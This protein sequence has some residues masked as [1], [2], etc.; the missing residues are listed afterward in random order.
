MGI[1]DKLKRGKKPEAPQAEKKSVVSPVVA[2]EKKTPSTPHKTVS[3]HAYRILLKPLVSEKAALRETAGEYTFVVAQTATK[4]DIKQAVAAVYGVMPA[5]VRTV[6]VEGKDTRSARGI[7]RRNDF[8]KAI[9]QLP[10]GKTM[11]IHEGV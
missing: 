6:H 7:G 2:P 10:K 5:K 9:V 3:G 8:K 1:F 11:S 4:T